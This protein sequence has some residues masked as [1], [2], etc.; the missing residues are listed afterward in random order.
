W[1][2]L[3]DT[4]RS[5]KDYPHALDAYKQAAF[6]LASN[7]GI[8]EGMKAAEKGIALTLPQISRSN[9][10]VDDGRSLASSSDTP[11]SCAGAVRNGGN[12]ELC[13]GLD[14]LA[15]ANTSKQLEDAANRVIAGFNDV[16][17]LCAQRDP[18]CGDFVASGVYAAARGYRRAGLMAKAIAV[19]RMVTMNGDLPGGKPFVALSILELGDQYFAIGV[20]DTA[21]DY[22][23]RYAKERGPGADKARDRAAFIRAAF[24]E[25][26]GPSPASSSVACPSPL[27]CGARYLLAEPRWVTGSKP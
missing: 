15:R 20:F 12:D 14:A 2:G 27:A 8:E 17:P 7:P 3:G 4:L 21:A 23:E 1:A 9:A 25:S 13:L 11:V 18:A 26:G 22:Y 6:L 24:R 16:K 5:N 10:P 19:S